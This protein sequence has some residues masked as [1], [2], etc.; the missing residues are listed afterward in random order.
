[1]F[2]FA[3]LL[4]VGQRGRGFAG[5]AGQGCCWEGKGG[6]V[7]LGLGLDLPEADEEGGHFGFWSEEQKEVVHEHAAA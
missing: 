3:D 7:V 6:L 2:G 4:G 5:I 1:M